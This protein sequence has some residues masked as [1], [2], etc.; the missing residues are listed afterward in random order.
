MKI[1]RHPNTII[2]IQNELLSTYNDAPLGAFSRYIG[3]MLDS[4]SIINQLLAQA[5]E[6]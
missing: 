6:E 1:K 4:P 5:I 3:S 2:N